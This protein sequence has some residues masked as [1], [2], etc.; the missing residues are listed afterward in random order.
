MAANCTD[1]QRNN[2]IAEFKR[3]SPSKGTIRENADAALIARSY[4]TAGP[5]DFLF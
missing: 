3:R 1:R 2:I 4:Q 5:R